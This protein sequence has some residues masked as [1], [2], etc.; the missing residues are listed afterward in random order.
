[1]SKKGS[2]LIKIIVAPIILSGIMVTPTVIGGANG[3]NSLTKQTLAPGHI[4]KYDGEFLHSSDDALEIHSSHYDDYYINDSY[5]LSDGSMLITSYDDDD[6]IPW[7]DREYGPISIYNQS[8]YN[9]NSH[10]K[11][12]VPLGFSQPYI[13]ANSIEDIRHTIPMGIDKF[14]FVEEYDSSNGLDPTVHY[15]DYSLAI[16]SDNPLNQINAWSTGSIQ[17]PTGLSPIAKKEYQEIIYDGTNLI[18]IS[19]YENSSETR[20]IKLSDDNLGNWKF[21]E[22]LNDERVFGTTPPTPETPTHSNQKILD[23]KKLP[24]R[25][26]LVLQEEQGFDTIGTLSK[27]AITATLIESDYNFTTELPAPTYILELDSIDTMYHESLSAEAAVI[28]DDKVLIGINEGKVIEYN[29]TTNAIF[30]PEQVLW[31]SNSTVIERD[32][33]IQIMEV[34]SNGDVIAYGGNDHHAT[35]NHY[36][37]TL[38]EWTY[39]IVPEQGSYAWSEEVDNDLD[40]SILEIKELEAKD[41]VIISGVEE[42]Y[43]LFN[44]TTNTFEKTLNSHDVLDDKQITHITELTD[45]TNPKND[46]YLVMGEEGHFN[47]LVFNNSVGNAEWSMPT[48]NSNV[49]LEVTNSATGTTNGSIKIVGGSYQDYFSIV[50]SVQVVIDDNPVTNLDRYNPSISNDFS[51][52]FSY[53]QTAK[54]GMFPGEYNVDIILDYET[55]KHDPTDT[56]KEVKELKALVGVDDPNTPYQVSYD[57]NVVN[58]IDQKDDPIINIT[59]GNYIERGSGKVSKVEARVI[60]PN[61]AISSPN[62][63]WEKVDT[64]NT[65]NKTFSHSFDNFDKNDSGYE[66]QIRLTYMD[67]TNRVEKTSNIKPTYI[68]SFQVIFPEETISTGTIVG[69]AVGSIALIGLTIYG[70]YLFLKKGK[71]D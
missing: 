53:S 59:N 45:T 21:V 27:K 35:L 17:L 28:S 57:S 56:T 39:K 52:E 40:S 70:G 26:T 10:A 50:E 16:A 62:N 7:E 1:M 4:S 48:L 11:S 18:G 51:H 2:T 15:F 24:N 19:N 23:I 12:E 66:I 5:P 36:N 68:N 8:K 63:E 6:D 22:G 71:T 47:K 3:L 33:T 20:L 67:G 29:P 55:E 61:T 54:V 44:M 42:G 41:L 60:D 69:I 37:S 31:N 32:P 9:N 64:V 14:A 49:D 30:S 58:N 25:D 65:T 34:L 38:E 46:H 13:F 43:G